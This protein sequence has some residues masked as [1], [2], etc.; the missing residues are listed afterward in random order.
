MSDDVPEFDRKKAKMAKLEIKPIQFDQQ[1]LAYYQKVF[2]A[3]IKKGALWQTSPNTKENI[4][5]WLMEASSHPKKV[6]FSIFYDNRLRGHVGLSE[7]DK[8]ARTGRIGLCLDS[9]TYGNGV[10]A[11][12]IKYLINYARGT[13]DLRIIMVE[14]AEEGVES[15]DPRLMRVFGSLGFVISP[16]LRHQWLH[17]D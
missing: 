3:N 17:L 12:A 11:R 9:L 13:L 8:V 6:I 14:S 2:P 7:I 1:T 5:C 10:A 4:Y 16:D 15:N